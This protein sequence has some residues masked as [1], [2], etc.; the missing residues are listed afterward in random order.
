MDWPSGEVN[1]ARFLQEYQKLFPCGDASEFANYI[2]NTFDKNKDN[3]IDFREFIWGVS[4]TDRGSLDEKLKCTRPRS[5]SLTCSTDS[6]PLPGTFQLYDI[7][8]NG[9]IERDELLQ[10]VRSIFKASGSTH[11]LSLDEGGPEDVQF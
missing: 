10:V 4:V 1:R 5:A 6:R 8:G 7:D 11:G 9:V 3:T 2:F